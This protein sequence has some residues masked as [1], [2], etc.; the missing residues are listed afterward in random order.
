[1]LKVT[2]NHSFL[3][4]APAV[5]VGT[6]SV[7]SFNLRKIVA[8]DSVIRACSLKSR[9]H[10]DHVALLSF[11]TFGISRKSPPTLQFPFS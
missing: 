7:P 3:V 1:M 2:S 4:N 10:L 11:K 9:S 8:A 5:D 6:M